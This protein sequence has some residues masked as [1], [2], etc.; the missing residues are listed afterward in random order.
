MKGDI[1]QHC[2]TDISSAK[3]ALDDSLAKLNEVAFE[4]DRIL[5]QLPILWGKA[6]GRN[7]TI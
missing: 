7:K 5:E 4:R 3:L 6:R 1:T 2:G